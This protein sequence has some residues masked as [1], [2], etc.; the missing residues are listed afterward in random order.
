VDLN[1]DLG[2]AAVLAEKWRRGPRPSA[3][4]TYND[5]YGLML[6]SALQNLGMEIPKDIALVG[7]DDLPLCE[8]IRPRLSSV[9]LGSVAPSRDIVTYI[10]DMIQGRNNITTPRLHRACKLILRD[11]G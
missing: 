2:E 6:M 7:C 11:S 9:N 10:D 1:Y 5:D 4:F 8:M 3:V